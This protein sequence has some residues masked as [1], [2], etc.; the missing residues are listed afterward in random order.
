MS[1]GA[2][3]Q[4]LKTRFVGSF[5][6]RRGNPKPRTA[7]STRR[8]ARHPQRRRRPQ[9][10]SRAY[11]KE[12]QRILAVSECQPGRVRVVSVEAGP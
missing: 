9:S 10:R 6:Y 7:E 12:V 4:S 5:S 8:R 1:I 11:L 3:Y 2:L